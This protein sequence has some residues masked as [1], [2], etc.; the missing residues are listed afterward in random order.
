[1]Y[2][3]PTAIS[4]IVVLIGVVVSFL[5]YKRGSIK[6]IKQDSK[7]SAVLS[8]KLDFITQGVNNIQLD[9]KSQ[10]LNVM[11]ISERVTRIEESSKSAHH[12]IDIIE[13]KKEGA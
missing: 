7:N 8:T 11:N 6:D 4:I 1:M 12:R 10:N 13:H 5:G 3:S 2:I 9:I